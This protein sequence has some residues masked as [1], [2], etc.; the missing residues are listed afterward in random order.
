MRTSV[1]NDSGQS[2]TVA[3]ARMS[4]MLPT[5][6]GTTPSSG[7][8]PR[9]LDEVKSFFFGDSSGATT[10][11][12]PGAKVAPGGHGTTCKVAPKRRGGCRVC[13]G[14]VMC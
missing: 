5:V 1:S 7:D 8:E 12:K 13:R 4:K 2:I 9:V 14:V 6:K 10:S 11:S 3:D